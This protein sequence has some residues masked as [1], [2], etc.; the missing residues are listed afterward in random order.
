M[1]IRLYHGLEAEAP[2]TPIEG[3]TLGWSAVIVLVMCWIGLRVLPD[4][5]KPGLRRFVR[6]W[7]AALFCFFG[8]VH[9]GDSFHDP[10]G[11][12]LSDAVLFLVLHGLGLGA[13]LS[14][15][16]VSWRI[17][18]GGTL[19]NLAADVYLAR[20]RRLPRF[21]LRLR[22]MQLTSAFIMMCLLAPADDRQDPKGVLRQ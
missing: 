21:L 12:Q 4:T 7:M 13:L 6:V 3:G 10:E 22:P 1:P 15:P 20:R 19:L 11:P 8:G 14:R 2:K 9:R 17:V 18:Q 5:S 16:D